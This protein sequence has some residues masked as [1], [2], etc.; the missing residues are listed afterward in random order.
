MTVALYKA[1][2][3]EARVYA[4][5]FFFLVLERVVYI[6]GHLLL[7]KLSLSVFAC[8]RYPGMVFRVFEKTGGTDGFKFKEDYGP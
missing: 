1:D 4:H 5:V 7:K 3:A 8:V 2:C 6:S